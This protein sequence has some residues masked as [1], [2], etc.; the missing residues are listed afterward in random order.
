MSKLLEVL[1]AELERLSRRHPR[2]CAALCVTAALRSI[3]HARDS[4]ERE[5]V[6][7]ELARIDNGGA[8]RMELADMAAR[9]LAEVKGEA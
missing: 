8:S 6:A 3:A 4:D 1:A 2:D 7:A 9:D 5:A